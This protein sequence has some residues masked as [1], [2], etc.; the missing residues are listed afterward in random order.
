MQHDGNDQ[1][2]PE[3]RV[4]QN[5]FAERAARKSESASI[6]VGST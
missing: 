3:A 2:T 6:P 1:L 4:K 5:D